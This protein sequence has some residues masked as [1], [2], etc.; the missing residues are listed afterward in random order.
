MIDFKKLS[1]KLS[2]NL[3]EPRD[4]F[5]SLPTRDKRYEYPRDVQT[6]VW[7]QWFEMRNQ[8]DCIIKMNTGSGKTVVGLL[9]LQS[10]LNENVG[11]AVFVVPDNY[12]VNQVC[13]EAKLLGIE[14]TTDA[15]DISFLRKRS[16]LVTN[17]QTL[18]NGKSKFGMRS[19]NNI[20]IGSIII[21]DV[22]ACLATIENQYTV[23]IPSTDLAY[24]EILGLFEKSLKK[25][26]ENKF[27]EIVDIKDP[28][29]SMLVPFWS[30]QE[31]IKNVYA[32]LNKQV[33]KEYTDFNFPLIKDCLSLCEC[34]VS[35]KEVEITPPSIPIHKIKSFI[36]AKRK[37][38]MSATLADDSS[39]VT[40]LNVSPDDIIKII[41]PEKANDIGD[42][43]ILF[44]QVMN[45]KITDDD[46]KRKLHE[47]SLEHNVVVIVPSYYRAEYWRDV[48]DAELSS[49]NLLDGIRRL[50]N[51]HVGLVVLINKYDGIDLPDDA[52][53]ILVIDG[54]PNMRSWYDSYEQNATPSNKRLCSEQIQKIE[55]GM[56]RGVRSNTDYC[57]VVLMGRRLA[58]VLYTSSGY[59]YFSQ[60]T[61]AQ[62]ELSEQLWEQL[63]GD[64]TIDDIMELTE[65]SISRNRDWISISKECL[66]E[67][68]YPT[69]PCFDS[70]AVAER[71]AFEYAVRLDYSNAIKM[72]QNESNR[73]SDNALRGLIKQKIAKYINFINPEEAQQILLSAHTN[74]MLLLNPIQGIQYQ[75]TQNTIAQSQFLMQVVNERKLT[76]NN[77]IIKVNSLLEKLVFQPDTYKQF[78][79][80]LKD[81]SF[82]IGIPSYRP[83]DECGKGPDNFWDVGNSEFFVIECKNGTITDKINKHDCNQLNG[84]INWFESL[85]AMSSCVCYPMMIHNSS[86]FEY[87]CSPSPNVKIMTPDLLESLKR[88]IENFATNLILPENWGNIAEIDRLLRQFNLCG[89]N[90]YDKYTKAFT[91][92]NK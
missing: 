30:W 22:H 3:I 75:K 20:D 2:S 37:I 49:L 45:K 80:A 13:G 83:E 44:P 82:L 90:I 79:S 88:N 92:S 50:K 69:T 42:R 28:Y 35:A 91:I 14:V 48:S 15:D 8:T 86:V 7:K 73:T 74:N 53:R 10:C 78:E 67:I 60:A 27:S 6:E 63:D 24:D 17:I 58:D 26:S 11:P 40:G 68:S 51:E 39:F 71:N 38:Y 89:K 70:C 18:V 61:K 43:L 57:S 41:S 34:M 1:S 36:N 21:D 55:Q 54:L 66:S 59:D 85:Y 33:N 81:I 64:C 5:M 84:S 4:I 16:I 52:C 87:A 62:F 46:I 32:I 12:L 29:Q 47:L 23:R 19:A 77:Y 25:Q 9:I 65:Y 76:G 56:G 31:Q 72:L